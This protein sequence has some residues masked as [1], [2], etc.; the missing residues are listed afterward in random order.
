[1][2]ILEI[3]DLC[4]FETVRDGLIPCRMIEPTASMYTPDTHFTARVTLKVT[5][6]R[7]GYRTG[8]VIET[9]PLHS[10][11][12]AAV[13]RHRYSTSILPYEVLT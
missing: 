3:G 9:T 4:Y 6:G 7:A 10:I 1:V 13:V 8:E 12:R 5:R 11:P 2:I